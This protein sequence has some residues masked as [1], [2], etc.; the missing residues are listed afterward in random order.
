M[1]AEAKD[2]PTAHETDPGTKPGPSRDQGTKSA[3]SRHQVDILKKGRKDAT[4]VDLMQVTGRTDR[5]KFR[6]QVLLPLLDQGLVEMTIP[7]K[8][9]S[10]RQR[11]RLTAAGRQALADAEADA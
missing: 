9:R 11:Y 3:L 5:T 8:P 1:H 6:H 10:S 4:L 2:Q 7:D